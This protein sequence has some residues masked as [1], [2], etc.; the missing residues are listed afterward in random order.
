M[1]KQLMSRI[2]KLEAV[3]DV[4]EKTCVIWPND[5][6]GWY[7]KMDDKERITFDTLDEVEAYADKFEYSLLVQWVD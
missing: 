2:K 1:K 4:D 6:G 7:T 5:N 3:Q